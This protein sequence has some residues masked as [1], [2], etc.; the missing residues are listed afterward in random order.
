MDAAARTVN[1]AGVYASATPRY[2]VEYGQDPTDADLYG[3]VVRETV[4]DPA[5]GVGGTYQYLYTTQ[6]LPGIP[7]P[8]DP[9]DTL[10]FRCVLTDRNDNQ[11]VYDFNAAQMPVRVEVI[12][13]RGKIDI[14]STVTW[15]SYVTW[16]QYNSQNQPVLQIL[17]AGN[18][19]AFTYENG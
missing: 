12:R 10:V 4:G 1:V 5:N 18:S 17:P 9:A 7:F 13:S 3:R 2:V 11:T 8:S 6:G 15:P 19:L 16:T 14:P